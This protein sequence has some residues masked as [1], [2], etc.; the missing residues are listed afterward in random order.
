VLPFFQEGHERACSIVDNSR[1]GL[2]TILTVLSGAVPTFLWWLLEGAAAATGT[3]G[4]F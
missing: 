3:E 4:R 2:G 1:A